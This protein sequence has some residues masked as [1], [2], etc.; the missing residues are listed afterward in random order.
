[1]GAYIQDRM[2]YKDLVINFGLRYDYIDIDN[3]V[4]ADPSRPETVWDKRNN[5]V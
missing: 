1:M 5:F 2:E 4:P 3:W